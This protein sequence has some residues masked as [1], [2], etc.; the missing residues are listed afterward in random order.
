MYE[1]KAPLLFALKILLPPNHK[2]ACTLEIINSISHIY[3]KNRGFSIAEWFVQSHLPKI[4]AVRIRT[5][6]SAS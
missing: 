5:I 2:L 1:F 6:I 3:R 4:Q